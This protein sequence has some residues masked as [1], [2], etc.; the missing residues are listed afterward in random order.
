MKHKQPCKADSYPDGVGLCTCKPA[1]RGFLV[2]QRCRGPV[3]VD[4]GKYGRPRYVCM[5]Q[6]ICSLAG[7]SVETVWSEEQEKWWVPTSR[8]LE[9]PGK[10]YPR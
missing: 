8:F 3:V 1:Q 9:V 5:S 6:G 4:L 2:C 7:M 10:W